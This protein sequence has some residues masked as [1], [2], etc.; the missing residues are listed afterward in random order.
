[1]RQVILNE[2]L[3]E[4]EVHLPGVYDRLVEVSVQS[5]AELLKEASGFVET[6]CPA[7]AAK[8][9]EAAFEKHGYRYQ[10]CRDCWTLYVSPRPSAAQMDWYVTRSPMAEFRRSEEYRNAT[11]RRSKERAGYSAGWIMQLR[12]KSGGGERP[13]VDVETRSSNYFAEI[14]RRKIQPF[15]AAGALAA[16]PADAAA[17]SVET[18]G[19]LEE[20][21]AGSA[22]VVS[23]FD[24]L[25]RRTEPLATVRA[26]YDA[27]GP[28]G[29]LAVTTRSG[30]GFD[31][32]VLWEH[33]STIYPV[34][35][36]NLISLEGMRRLLE[37]VG[38]EVV[39]ESTPG[40]L[41]VQLV[42]K[43]LKERPD[44]DVPRFLKYFLTHRDR[45][46]RERLQQL[47]QENLLSS[48]LRIVARKGGKPSPDPRSESH[49]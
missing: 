10:L 37:R 48:H 19:R 8:E 21:K 6:A 42:E 11:E 43:V 15:I 9:G 36:I 27:L 35:H 32:Q 30:S 28:D 3:S 29:L 44:A 31:V 17:G 12:P 2:G 16:V 47:L 46:A 39:E 4:T 13:V 23:L 26:A 22:G 40:Q 20:V 33:C 14:L 18:V 45:Q 41:D 25:E 49:G 34:E 38:F 5:A 1:V 7:C 24:V